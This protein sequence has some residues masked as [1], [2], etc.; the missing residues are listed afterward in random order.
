[1]RK[2]LSLIRRLE[3]I[4]KELGYCQIK[5]EKEQRLATRVHFLRA[6]RDRLL[7]V[8]DLFPEQDSGAGDRLCGLSFSEISSRIMDEDKHLDLDPLRNSFLAIGMRPE[9][10][11][12]L[13]E[14]EVEIKDV[15]E[16]L[17]TFRV[18]HD[19]VAG[20]QSER[21]HALSSFDLSGDE[22]VLA[23]SDEFEVTEND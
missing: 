2:D 13:E 12:E 8:L 9:V 1:M 17:S 15:S 3:K 16:R 10:T 20:L 4:E 22:P 6:H 21:R 11:T 5:L 7:E 18:F 19:K 14:L 23:I